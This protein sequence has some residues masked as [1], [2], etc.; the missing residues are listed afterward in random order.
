MSSLCFQDA[1]LKRKEY[2]ITEDEFL[3]AIVDHCTG[4]RHGAN[5]LCNNDT[6]VPDKDHKGDIGWGHYI[7]W[8]HNIGDSFT[9]GWRSGY[10][11]ILTRRWKV[12]Y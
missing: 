10:I 7:S 11:S 12:W 8:A 9:W 4:V 3:K 2:S 1:V 5:R 6:I